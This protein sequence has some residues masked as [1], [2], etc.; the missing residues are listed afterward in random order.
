MC[1]SFNILTCKLISSIIDSQ[2][3][4]QIFD[5]L[6]CLLVVPQVGTTSD[7]VI[8]F[9][10]NLSGEICMEHP[11][12]LIETFSGVCDFVSYKKE[13]IQPSNV[14]LRGCVLRNTRYIIGA[15]VNTGHD[16][17]IMMSSTG[18]PSKTSVLENKATLQIQRIIVLLILVCLTG[19]TG[20][21]V[22]NNDLSVTIQDIWYLKW[23][24]EEGKTWINQLFYFL[25]LHATFIPV[26]LYVSMS[27]ARYLQSH[28]MNVDLDMCHENSHSPALVRTMTLNEE[29]GQISHIFTDKTGTLTCNVMDFRKVSICGVSYGEG[30][31]EIGRVAWKLQSKEI[32]ETTLRYEELA[33]QNAMPHVSFYSPE[34]E[35]S[36]KRDI[37]AKRRNDFFWRVVAICHDI[38]PERM[39]GQIKLSASNPD[40]EA[41]V[42]AAKYFGFEFLDNQDS[43]ILIHNHHTGKQEKFRHLETI[44][45]NSK[46]KRMSVVV[47]ALETDEILLITKGADSVIFNRL[48]DKTHCASQADEY[49]GSQ[50]EIIVNTKKHLGHFAVEGLRCLL[51]SYRRL[52]REEYENWHTLYSAASTSLSQI[53]LMENGEINDIEDLQ[54]KLEDDLLLLGCTAVEDRLQDG[55]PNCISLL[56]DAGIKIW[57][58]TG[59]KEETAINIAIAC[60]LLP[61]KEYIRYVIVNDWSCPT[62]TDIIQLLESERS[63]YDRDENSGNL[64][65]RAF[66]I[67]GPSLVKVMA[68]KKCTA[69]LLAFSKSCEAVVCCRVS[70]D[71]KKEITLLIKNGTGDVRTLAV[72]DGANDVAMIQAAH[73]G[74]GIK[75]EE[76]L[77]AVNSAD[78]ALAQFQ[79]LAPLLLKHGRSNYIRLA[80]LIV[81]MFYK[82]LFMSLCQFCFAFLNGFSGQKYYTEGG[83]QLFNVVFTSVPIL[84]LGASDVD[85]N[86]QTIL[87]YP[88]IYW[89]CIQNAYFRTS[90]LWFWLLQAGIEACMC[91]YL[92]LVLLQNYEEDFGS[93]SS[94]WEA[95]ALC[96]TAVVVICSLKIFILQ[97]RLNSFHFVV[98]MISIL[99]WVV[100]ASIVNVVIMID[101]NWNNIWF[102]LLH[103]KTFWMA[104]L[105]IVFS[106]LI[107]DAFQCFVDRYVQPRNIHI[108]QEDEYFNTNR[109]YKTI[110]Q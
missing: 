109:K 99:S 80:S 57:M 8:K 46:R 7:S 68:N 61:P 81:Y 23:D 38:I 70:P 29:L 28:A 96:F 104:L 58:L 59:D 39:D 33:K 93:S 77:Q 94:L 95:G 90:R 105:I 21:A 30:I 6:N 12:K 36:M 16:T 4:N 18:T 53:G 1:T 62:E 52:D 32:S 51:I 91:T 44:G 5:E 40:D 56:R 41:N 84:I 55:V 79:Y 86:Y 88:R 66:I 75:G 45:F 89:D 102:N 101:Y 87:K 14:L 26:S 27:A 76:G 15:V 60:N 69:S 100:V 11:N 48:A 110:R 54:D 22:W 42:A 34:Y 64:Y 103:S 17:K 3:G 97:H 106:A 10:S 72:G 20:Q 67:D 49:F 31:T 47:H 19:A 25:L 108:L 83:I 63:E 65:P 73:V 74:V 78:F 35:K 50:E 85:L 9:V 37:L 43:V 98:L 24:P 107:K 13:V 71:Q 2:Y 82:N 92:S